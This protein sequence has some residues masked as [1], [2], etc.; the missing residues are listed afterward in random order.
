MVRWATNHWRSVRTTIVLEKRATE[1]LKTV[2]GPSSRQVC[3]HELC[4]KFDLHVVYT[5]GLLNPRGDFFS[6]WADTANAALGNVYVHGTAEPDGDVRDM[7]AAEK[8]ELFAPLPVFRA[9]LAPAVTRSCSKGAP[10]ATG[11]PKSHPAPL[12]LAPMQGG[13]KQNQTLQRLEEIVRITKF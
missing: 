5:P 10:W 6:L 9:I 8:E 13:T 4:C 1:D 11:T 2:E 7:M 12:A 3:W